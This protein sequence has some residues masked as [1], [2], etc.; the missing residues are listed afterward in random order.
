MR[1]E[2]GHVLI[3]GANGRFGRHASA[4]FL[5]AGWRVTALVRPGRAEP[6]PHRLLADATDA[7]ALTRAA[8]GA[9][10]I[11]NALNPP[12]PDW[13][14]EV[15]RLTRAVIQAARATGA[16]V[17]LP[18]NVYNFGST[19]PATLTA[20]TEQAADTAKGAIRRTME[21]TYAASGVRTILLRAGDFI[22]IAVSGNWFESHI[23]K[24][25]R[26]GVVIY[27][28]PLDRLH[29]WAFL[30]DLARA[31]VALAE[32]RDALAPFADI[33][34]PGHA[35]TGA[36]LVAAMEEVLG[37]RLRVRRFP[38]TLVALLSP[39]S[40][41]PREVREMRYLWEVPHR[42]DGTAFAT[43]VPDFRPT[44]LVQALA[45][46]LAAQGSRRSTQTRRWSEETGRPL[47]MSR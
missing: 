22:D 18:G 8:Q 1:G 46:S 13:A 5:A 24:R 34:F 3:L 31:A 21:R 38:W 10:L 26:D 41:M 37:Q 6:A 4:A 17:L 32:R 29:A 19:M 9:D 11:V 20:A 33:P 47:P 12:Y 44:P 36:G 2:P 16:T 7:E 45:A 40:P 39:F 30:P 28:G 42:L 15:P 27:P 25:A 35:V 23:A 43:L 14:R